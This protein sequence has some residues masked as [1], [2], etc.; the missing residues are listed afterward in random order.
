MASRFRYLTLLAIVALLLAACGPNASSNTEQPSDEPS[1]AASGVAGASGEPTTGDVSGDLFAYGFG[2][3]TGDTVATARVD[4]VLELYPDVN[5]EFSESGF[6]SQ[7]FLTALQSSDPPD[8]AHLPRNIIGSYIARGVLDP[9]D[10][11]IESQ[12][13]DMGNFYDSAVNS[14]SADGTVFGFPE[15]FNTRLWVANDELFTEAGT[16]VADFDFGSWD[17]IAAANDA[18]LQ[19]DG[20]VQRIGIDPKIPEFLAMWAVANGGQLISDDGLESLL[21][22]PEVLEALEYTVGLVNAHGGDSAAFTDFRG[23]WDFFGAENE[24][25]TGQVGAFPI[26]QWYLNVLAENSP[27]APVT[28][29]LF[30]SRDGSDPV[31][32]EDGSA[33]AI[34]SASDNKEAACAVAAGMVSTDAWVAAANARAA[35][36]AADDLPF[37]GVYTANREADDEIFSSIV[38]LADHP[39]FEAAVQLVVD[40]QESAFG[41][42]PSPAAEEFQQALTTAVNSALT[43]A[44]PAAALQTADEEAQSAIDAAASQ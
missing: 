34:V 3:E 36:R 33:W 43:G 42:P 16:P 26:E 1:G 38:D 41:W 4:A 29:G 37:T 35:E 22:T 32:L 24:F 23:T 8:L 27:D 44:D 14:V 18:I 13:V 17:D 11:C 20:G 19:A 9:L 21:D 5:I 15:F 2:Y 25:A 31:T 40:N 7:G 30:I 28:G 39:N 6:D 10:S 12:G